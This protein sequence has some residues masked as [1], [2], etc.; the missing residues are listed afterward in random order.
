M[1]WGLLRQ[2]R[3]R[4]GPLSQLSWNNRNQRSDLALKWGQTAGR[5]CYHLLQTETAERIRHAELSS[6]PFALNA[7]GMPQDTWAEQPREVWHS[8][9]SKNKSQRG[10][11]VSHWNQG[12]P[13]QNKHGVRTKPTHVHKKGTNWNADRFGTSVVPLQV[14]AAGNL[15]ASQP[16]IS[17]VSAQWCAEDTP[18]CLSCFLLCDRDRGWGNS[19]PWKYSIILIGLHWRLTIFRTVPGIY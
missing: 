8:L 1:S 16:G 2:H 12:A 17:A 19:L 10:T 18:G 4:E 13:G 5:D 14:L 6:F 11:P 3:H 7:L 15:T 9:H